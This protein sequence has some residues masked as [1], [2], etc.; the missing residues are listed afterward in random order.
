MPSDG[1]QK[2][3]L[4][5][6]MPVMIGMG[7]LIVGLVVAIAVVMMTG[8]AAERRAQEE[9]AAK[10]DLQVGSAYEAVFDERDE[11]NP[12]YAAAVA[13]NEYANYETDLE[14]TVL[15]DYTPAEVCALLG[16]SC[17]S[18]AGP[19]QL[20]NFVKVTPLNTNALDYYLDR[21]H[22]VIVRAYGDYPYTE[23]GNTLV[24]Y[25]AD[26][27]YGQSFM[28]FMPTAEGG[29]SLKLWRDALINGIIGIPNF[30]VSNET[31]R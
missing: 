9:Q 22:V 24:I 4:K 18:L 29:T 23:Q 1:S 19:A 7:V 28:V 25:A 16:V 20:A 3:T 26:Y 2:T 17:A 8:E 27:T 30:Y 31:F 10:E 6:L 5:R 21:G 12:V 14:Y 11:L 13:A 15:Y